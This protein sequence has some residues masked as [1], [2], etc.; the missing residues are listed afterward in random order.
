MMCDSQN[1]PQL[2][3]TPLSQFQASFAQGRFTSPKFLRVNSI[4]HVVHRR[5]SFRTL[6]SRKWRCFVFWQFLSPVK[7]SLVSVALICFLH[8]QLP[9]DKHGGGLIIFTSFSLGTICIFWSRLHNLWWDV[10]GRCLS[11][12]VNYHTCHCQTGHRNVTIRIMVKYHVHVTY[13]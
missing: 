13:I 8:A 2:D 1:L 9:R 10:T 3:D 11:S 12:Y 5:K 4:S 7:W 6:M